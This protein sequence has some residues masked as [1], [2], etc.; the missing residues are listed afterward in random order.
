MESIR[1]KFVAVTAILAM[2]VS[3]LSGGLGGIRLMT[4][5]FRALAGGA[6]FAVTAVVL[7]VLALRF[8]PEIFSSPDE[9][10]N[11]S[12][13]SPRVDIIVGDETEGDSGAGART[14]T[15][16]AAEADEALEGET[17][18]TLD[19]P[20]NGNAGDLESFSDTFTNSDEEKSGGSVVSSDVLDGEY[21][22]EEIA[23]AVHT[24]IERDKK[25]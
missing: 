1:W 21:Q 18:D 13:S 5:L 19:G 11:D 4:L 9:F 24:V 15:E 20:D 7:N 22:V 10:E 3:L 8:Y 17:E 6:V 25:G 14:D 12:I 2:A 16:G 23:Q